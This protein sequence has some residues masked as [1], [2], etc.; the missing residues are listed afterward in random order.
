[1]ERQGQAV[2][3]RIKRNDIEREIPLKDILE[4]FG[5]PLT[6]TDATVSLE[7]EHEGVRLIVSTEAGE[8]DYPGFNVDAKDRNGR[9]IYL[10]NMEFPNESFPDSVATRLYAGY[11]DFET[12]EPI[13]LVRT[14]LRSVEE[15]DRLDEATAAMNGMRKYVHVDYDAAAV[16][17]W[18]SNKDLEEHVEEF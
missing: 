15:I 9:D 6:D 17:N 18:K 4:K 14:R 7:T 11:A 2:S 10:A 5:I 13:A 12:D 3:L 1:M 16:R 8:K